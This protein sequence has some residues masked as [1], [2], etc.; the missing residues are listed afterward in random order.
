MKIII[1]ITF[2]FWAMPSWANQDNRYLKE[3]KVLYENLMEQDVLRVKTSLGYC[4]VLEFPEKPML[5]TIG[6]NSMIQVEIPQNSKSVVIKPLRESGETNLFVFTPSRRFNY[7]VLIGTPNE[8]DY[9]VDAKESLQDTSKTPK[10][11]S[12]GTVLKMARSYD[13]F[14]RFG[15]INPREF[16]QKEL[17]YQC[18]Y[19]Q[20]NIDVIEAFSHK[21]PH[22]LLLHIAVHNLTDETVNL[23]EQKTDI[24]VNDE[25]FIPQYVL[26]DNNQLAASS[27]TDGWLILENSFVSIDNKLSLTLGVEDRDYVCQASAS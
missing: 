19:P 8:M 24:L 16:I 18:S 11:L 21:D 23:T 26:F 22:Y 20:V 2:M 12:M 15:L 9:V 17:F 10:K 1:L 5:V 3:G 13:F 25:K 7:N 14:K 4:T 27:K 6:D